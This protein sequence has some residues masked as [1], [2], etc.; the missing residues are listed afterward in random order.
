MKLSTIIVTFLIVA[1]VYAGAYIE[2]FHARSESDDVRLEWQTSEETNLQN[3]VV[4]RKTPQSSYTEIASVQPK[5]NNSYYTFTDQNA[6]KTNDMVFVYR[7]KIV[8]NNNQVTYSA[9]VTVTHSISSIA[10]RTW[11]SI[12]AMFR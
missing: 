7:L 3:F 2:Y 8:D 9:D 11:G 12:K 6:Y 10:K 1:T 5:G 4:E